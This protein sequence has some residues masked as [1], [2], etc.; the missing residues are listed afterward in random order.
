MQEKR[1]NYSSEVSF[2]FSIS[3]EDFVGT[4]EVLVQE[5]PEQFGNFVEDFIALFHED[6]EEFVFKSGESF[7]IKPLC[8]I[9]KFQ[10]PRSIIEE[11]ELILT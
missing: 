5:S 1:K 2:P 4:K 9:L 10:H 8:P 11:C 7:L 3:S 6:E